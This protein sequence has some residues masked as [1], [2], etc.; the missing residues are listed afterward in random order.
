MIITVLLGTIAFGMG[1][2][3]LTN[4][5]FMLGFGDLQISQVL[6][7]LEHIFETADVYRTVD[8]WHKKPAQ[9]IIRVIGELFT[10]QISTTMMFMTPIMMTT[11]TMLLLVKIYLIGMIFYLMMNCLKFIDNI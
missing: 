5:Q 9:E 10:T 6:D 1:V 7:N 11:M 8:I 3:T 4:I 2:K